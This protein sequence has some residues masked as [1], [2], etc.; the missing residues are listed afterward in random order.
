MSCYSTFWPKPSKDQGP[1]SPAAVDEGLSQAPGISAASWAQESGL[2]RRAS[3]ESP[4]SL[5][6]RQGAGE[7]HFPACLP[8]FLL[9]LDQGGTGI[10]AEPA[11][12]SRWAPGCDAG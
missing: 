3:Q 8:S 6:W 1:K 2:Q 11:V 4:L 7:G 9:S 5:S 10:L 12:S